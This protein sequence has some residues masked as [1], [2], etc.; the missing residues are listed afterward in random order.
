MVFITEKGEVYHKSLQCSYLRM[1]KIYAP[2]ETGEEI[3]FNGQI[4][5]PCSYCGDAEDEFVGYVTIY[6]GCYHRSPY[7]SRIYREVQ[8]IP[9]SEVGN[10]RPCSKCY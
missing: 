7:C 10:R 4:Y 1:N 2:C 5:K 9:R 8:R 3:V 6:G